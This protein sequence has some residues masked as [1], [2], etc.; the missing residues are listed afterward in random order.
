MKPSQLLFIPLLLCL[1]LTSAPA[2]SHAA[3]KEARLAYA[4][5]T[6]A[7]AATHVVQ[8]V[9]Q[10]KMGYTV[11]LARMRPD[12]LWKQTARGSVDGFV[13]AWLPSLHAQALQEAEPDVVNLG[14]NCADT[15]VGLVVPAYVTIDSIKELDAHAE[16]FN[17]R[18]TGIDRGA[19]IMETTREAMAAYKLEN[20]EL[21]EGSGAMMT[22]ILKQRIEKRKWV[23]VT[24]WT[25]HWL[26]HRYE[27]KYLKD[28]KKVFG[29][30]EYIKTI[31]RAGLEE[32]KPELYAVLNNFQWTA[33]DLQTVMDWS[34]QQGSPYEAAL[35]WIRRNPEKVAAWLPE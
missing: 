14:V 16:R 6:S 32:E 17:G 3:E 18:I 12:A 10:E 5:W 8:A 2:M 25:P 7:I 9:L 23:V 13:C 19:G 11:S 20:L 1:L 29:S 15:R 34:Q 4:P 26:F 27:L 24:G 30:S 28:P 21:E 35:Q 33:G 31:V 22:E